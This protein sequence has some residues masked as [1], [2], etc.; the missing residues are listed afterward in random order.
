MRFPEWKIINIE[1]ERR[2][3][4]LQLMRHVAANRDDMQVGT[5]TPDWRGRWRGTAQRRL[6]ALPRN[7]L[8]DFVNTRAFHP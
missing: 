7:V 6:R 1:A 4:S 2:L 8:Q 5:S 3:E